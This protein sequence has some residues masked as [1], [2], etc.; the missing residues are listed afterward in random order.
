MCW[1][2]LL[3]SENDVLRFRVDEAS[4]NQFLADTGLVEQVPN[5]SRGTCRV[6]NISQE[7]LNLLEKQLSQHFYIEPIETRLHV[8]LG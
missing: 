5:L 7:R 2:I 3:F 8:L 4:L 1:T 6:Y